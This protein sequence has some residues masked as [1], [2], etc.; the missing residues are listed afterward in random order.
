MIP[1]KAVV[2]GASSHFCAEDPHWEQLLG[3][4]SRG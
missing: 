2:I 4:Q 3:A 1:T